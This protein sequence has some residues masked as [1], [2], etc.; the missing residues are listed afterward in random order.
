[1]PLIFQPGRKF[2][3]RQI[4]TVATVAALFSAGILYTGK[5][6][7]IPEHASARLKT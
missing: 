1:M 7:I 2:L 4:Y 5:D 6:G 3:V